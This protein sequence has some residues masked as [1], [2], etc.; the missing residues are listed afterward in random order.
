[1]PE[2]F[3]RFYKNGTRKGAFTEPGGLREGEKFYFDG[4]GAI[5]VWADY[6]KTPQLPKTIE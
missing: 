4:S 2:V 5:G 1:L 3:T 6:L